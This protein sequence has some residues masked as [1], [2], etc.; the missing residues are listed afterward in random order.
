V[1]AK[2]TA[3]SSPES[4]SQAEP[5]KIIEQVSESMWPGVPVVPSM[6]AGATD[7]MR[8]RLA[9][10]PT[11]GASGMFIEFGENRLHGKDER[12]GVQSFYESAEFLYRAVK[13]LSK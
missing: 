4:S 10:I 7:G 11:Y 3:N 2:G 8:L 9:G 5:Y 12:I 13:A 1:L 6:S